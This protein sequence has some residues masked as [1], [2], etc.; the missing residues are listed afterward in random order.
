[1]KKL[2]TFLL[3]GL[4]F[5][6][7][8]SAITDK[9]FTK[10][11]EK[12]TTLTNYGKVELETRNWIDVFGWFSERVEDIELKENTESCGEE[13]YAIKEITMYKDGKLV[14]DV[15]FET[16]LE[17][18]SRV[19]QPIRDY[20]FYIQD[21]EISKEVIDYE[22]ECYAYKNGSEGNYCKKIEV[23]SHMQKEAVW[24]EY[25]YEI[26]P[27]GTYKLKL[28]GEKKPSKTIDWIIKSQGTWI[29]EW[30][31]WGSTTLTDDIESYYKF[32]ETTGNVVDELSNY[33]GTANGTTRGVTGKID[34]GIDLENDK[35]DYVSIGDLDLNS[36]FSIN[37]WIKLESLGG[38]RI[39]IDK[40]TSDGVDSQ[41]N[42][43]I[44][45]NDNCADTPEF[46]VGDGFVCSND[47]LNTGEWYMIT[48]VYDYSTTNISIFVNGVYIDSD[49]GTRVL[50]DGDARIGWWDKT[51][52]SS[53]FDGVI[54]ELGIWTR[55]LS[56]SEI[57]DLYNAGDGSTYPLFTSSIVDLNSPEDNYTSST[58]EVIFNCSATVIGGSTLTNMSFWIEGVLNETKIKTGTTNESIFTKTLSEGEYN[59]TCQACDSDGDCGFAI[60]NRTVSVDADSPVLL[61][62]YGNQTFNYGSLTQNYT[63]N[64]TITDTNL[65]SCWIEYN[66]TNNTIDCVSGTENTTNFQLESNLFNATLYANDSAGNTASQFFEWSYRV[67][68]NSRTFNPTST[69]TTNEDFYLNITDDGTQIPIIY[70][71]YNGTQYLS[72]LVDGLYYNS[73]PVNDIGVNQLFWNISYGSL[74][75]N[76]Y[77]S[78]QTVSDL[79]AIE[80]V[81]GSCSA[82]L[83]KVMN[84]TFANENNLSSIEDVEVKYNIQYGI[85]NPFGSNAYGSINATEL[86][87]CLNTTQ[88]QNYTI[89]Y[90]E[91][92]YSKT[93]Y[94][95]RRYYIFEGTKISNI[96]TY[97]TLYLL[98]S[99]DSTSFLIEIQDPTL[100]PYTQKYT[101]LLKWYPELDEYKV[102]EMGKTDDKGQTVKKVKIEDVDYRIGVYETDGSLI[103]LANPIRMVCLATPCSYTLT[104]KSDEEYTFNDIQDIQANIVYDS[105]V[106]TLTYNDPS[107]NTEFM[108]LVVYKIGGT[109]TD[110]R[111]CS[112]NGT[113]FTGI[114]TCNV[115][116]ESGILKAV[117]YR[118]ASPP[119]TVAS[120]I[121]DTAS[122]VFQG[123]FGLFLQFLITLTLVMLG[124]FSPIT[125]IILGFLSLAM[126]VFFLKTITFPI[127]IGLAILSA[128]IIHFLR[129]SS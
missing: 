117:A 36:N 96:T 98:P 42:F 20:Q 70:F 81:S 91:I 67:F 118:S 6:S 12:S 41:T 108:E 79:T 55:T 127:M 93:D 63:M 68:E 122:S 99:A 120:K 72:T 97:N 103:N 82:G 26:L 47:T 92:D 27:S 84:F 125:A 94:S 2:L 88:S 78:S 7:L 113:S 25:N 86:S 32:E 69:V 37:A 5:I 77:N 124:I 66:E 114:L 56:H 14:D 46:N 15:K 35:I 40:R 76:T 128:I 106:F 61:I 19:E 30:A 13:C 18:G 123:T 17:D 110:E 52:L 65:D 24:K 43:Q 74:N 102:V 62:N 71:N 85:S 54:D 111:L 39:V 9:T 95:S 11:I 8:A 53:S 22:T 109:A 3:I 104:I 31:V 73:I 112:S 44:E 115:S 1:M 23:G 64:Y 107:Q 29:N 101:T 48:G 16:I 45:V 126:G 105:G 34:N 89:G 50:N 59:W 58:D 4:F 100:T 10:D 75:F 51:L 28:I 129:G 33:M 60:E 38:R 80:I 116:D 119:Y 87:I 49:T 121:V 83:N 21:G 90:G 57:E